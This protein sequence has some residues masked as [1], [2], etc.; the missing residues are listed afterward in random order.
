MSPTP[1]AGISLKCSKTYFCSTFHFLSPS[2]FFSHSQCFWDW[3]PSEIYISLS[4]L[5]IC[6]TFTRLYLCSYWCFCYI[7]LSGNF[8]GGMLYLLHIYHVSSVYFSG[9]QGSIIRIVH[10]NQILSDVKYSDHIVTSTGMAI[11]IKLQYCDFFSI[12]PYKENYTQ[13]QIVLFIHYSLTFHSFSIAI[14]I[15]CIC[16]SYIL[17]M[18]LCTLEQL[19]WRLLCK[20]L[21]Y[22]HSYS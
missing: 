12:S 21:L 8:W 11:R 4:L 15:L 17:H 20:V 10:R 22:V 19:P 16:Y 13:M 1:T 6:E 14:V 3:D 7:F 2:Q 18:G 5:S 9:V